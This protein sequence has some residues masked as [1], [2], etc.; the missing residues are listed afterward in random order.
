MKV[1]AETGCWTQNQ[2]LAEGGGGGGDLSGTWS[3]FTEDAK[4]KLKQTGINYLLFLRVSCF[5]FIFKVNTHEPQLL[6]PGRTVDPEQQ[7]VFSIFQYLASLVVQATGCE[8][9]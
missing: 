2:D 4:I 7:V 8:A 5:L 3:S 6:L 1:S 9:L